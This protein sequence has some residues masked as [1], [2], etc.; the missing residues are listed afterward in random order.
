[1]IFLELAEMKTSN[2][3]NGFGVSNLIAV[4]LFQIQS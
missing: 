3:G 1:M 2:V 4:Q